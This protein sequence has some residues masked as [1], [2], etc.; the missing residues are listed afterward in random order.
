[1]IINL[2]SVH[3][4]ILV[5]IIVAIINITTVLSDDLSSFLVSNF[6]DLN[7]S[8][9]VLNTV[10]KFLALILLLNKFSWVWHVSNLL[11]HC[12]LA[13]IVKINLLDI[14]LS[15]LDSFLSLLH[16]L[17]F[18]FHLNRNM[19]LLSFSIVK[20]FLKTVEGLNSVSSIDF[21]G[22]KL[23]VSIINI[24]NMFLVFNL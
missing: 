17:L 19:S 18:D 12:S 9:P 24:F 10:F 22:E 21:Q 8:G 2:N 20:L 11:L 6:S 4:I 23:T 15:F 16:L 1:M 14:L 5:N 7:L 3:I 13:S